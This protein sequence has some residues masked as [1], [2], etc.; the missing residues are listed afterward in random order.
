MITNGFTKEQLIMYIDSCEK[1]T[2][3][4]LPVEFFYHL[5]KS[6]QALLEQKPAAEIEYATSSSID[7]EY[8]YSVR[9]THLL[10]IGSKFYAA[11]VAPAQPVIPDV[12]VGV[13]TAKAPF[14]QTA[15][16]NYYYLTSPSGSSKAL[17]VTAANEDNYY[18]DD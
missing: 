1:G 5:A 15:Y 16:F 12:W 3:M 7:G 14:G 10:P 17:T 4:D 9:S 11:P 13:D 2:T 18:V 8:I 6:M